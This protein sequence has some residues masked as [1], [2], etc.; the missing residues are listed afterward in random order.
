[1]S[2]GFII[3]SN[4]AVIPFLTEFESICEQEKRYPTVREVL[5]IRRTRRQRWFLGYLFLILLLGCIAFFA[6]SAGAAHTAGAYTI[7]TSLGAHIGLW[8]YAIH[9]ARKVIQKP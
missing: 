7:L 5:L 3:L 4:F 9:R 1:M 2:V 6:D 8:I